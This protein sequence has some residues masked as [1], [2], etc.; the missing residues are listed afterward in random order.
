MT[1]PGA[2]E[3]SPV[4]RIASDDHLSWW[5]IMM[6]AGEGKGRK[7]MKGCR[8]TTCS[9][10]LLGGVRRRFLMAVQGD[11][12]HQRVFVMHPQ[13]PS[14]HSL[15]NLDLYPRILA[16]DRNK[17]LYVDRTLYWMVISRRNVARFDY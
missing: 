4:V 9:Y 2:I 8:L 3:R 12:R 10:D 5:D 13:G 1:R 17:Y 7:G 14:G 15:H 11:I 16:M 6:G